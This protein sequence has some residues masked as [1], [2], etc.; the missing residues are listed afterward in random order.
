[1]T[2]QKADLAKMRAEVK[3][4]PRS[5][6]KTAA[7]AIVKTIGEVEALQRKYQAQRAKYE[8]K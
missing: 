5:P 6:A 8:A 2:D 4:M 3:A 7:G 1:M